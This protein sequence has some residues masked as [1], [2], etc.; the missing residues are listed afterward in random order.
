MGCII[1]LTS[2]KTSSEANMTLPKYKISYPILR[3]STIPESSTV[4]P[5]RLITISEENSFLESSL[6]EN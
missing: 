1:R 2:A 5:N 4:L 3:L 6:E